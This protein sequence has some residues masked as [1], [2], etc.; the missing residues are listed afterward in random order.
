MMAEVGPRPED[1]VPP[2]VL[3]ARQV[4]ARARRSDNGRAYP[5]TAASQGLE[6]LGAELAATQALLRAESAAEVCAVVSTLVHDLGG[7]LVPARYADPATVVPVDVSLGLSEPLLPFAEPVSVA[8][9]RLNAVLP[10]FLEGARLVLSRLRGDLQRDEEATRDQLTGVLTRRAWMRRLSGAAPGDSVCLIDLDHFKAVN[11]TGGHAAGDAVLR[12]I[13]ALILR[14]FR[15][16]D[17]CG[18]YGGDELVCLAPGLPGPGLVARCEQL[19]RAWEQERPAAGARVGLSIGVAEVRE[20]GGRAA[21]QS[22]DSA[23]YRGKTEGRNR[24]VL[25][26]L[27][28]YGRGS[29]A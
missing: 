17:S 12:A 3:A 5:L 29:P 11:D 18:R 13:G 27:N 9:M 10:A 16:G 6:A 7:T 2:S 26:S 8:A 24:T 28:D 25:A 23:M 1:A 21:L 20:G 15:V 4:G 22:A 14:T 19:R